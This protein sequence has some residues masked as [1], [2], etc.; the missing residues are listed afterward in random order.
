[1]ALDLLDALVP[2]FRCK[3][4]E[5]R[6]NDAISP[7]PQQ[8][9]RASRRVRRSAGWHS[10][11]VGSRRRSPRSPRP[12]RPASGRANRSASSRARLELTR[13]PL[14]GM[15]VR[16]VT[17][18]WRDQHVESVDPLPITSPWAVAF[19]YRE[20]RVGTSARL[21]VG[22]VDGQISN[23]RSSHEDTWCGHRQPGLRE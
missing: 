12:A 14:Q 1:M 9:R 19:P 16:V 17:L 2:R 22:T 20:K 4:E 23:A 15:E 10:R 5:L 11:S 7:A 13:A 6:L 18:R 3:R 21:R 8:A